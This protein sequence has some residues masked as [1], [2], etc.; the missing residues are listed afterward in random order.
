MELEAALRRVTARMGQSQCNI[1]G[2]SGVWVEVQ[3]HNAKTVFGHAHYVVDQTTPTQGTSIDQSQ[4][5]KSL[6]DG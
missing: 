4:L 6:T 3:E 5:F 1:R 2:R